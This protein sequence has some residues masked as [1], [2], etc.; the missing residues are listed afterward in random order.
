MRKVDGKTKNFSGNLPFT[1]ADLA[2]YFQNGMECIGHGSRRKCFR[3][4]G[5]PFCVK[6]YRLP[7]EYTCKTRSGVRAEIKLLRFSKRWNTSCQEW[8]YHKKLQKRLPKELFAVFP[9]VVERVF[10]PDRGW[11]I[12]ENLLVNPDGSPMQRVIAEMERTDDPDLRL[13]L[14]D[15]LASLC[16]SL[17]HYTVRFYDPPNVMVQ[18]RTDGSY[19]LRIVD[20]EP[21]GHTFIPFVT[22]M[23]AFIRA[24]V[25]RR[26]DRYLQRLIRRFRLAR[27][28]KRGK[29]KR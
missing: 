21:M 4:P 13:D 7:S 28:V 18:W 29:E 5:Q 11:G 22:S 9:E 2:G 25:R 27:D 16:D 3:V 24:K 17:V 12:S 23:P 20:F 14:F 1:Q 19:R 10:L 6:F 15:S 8:A 26:T